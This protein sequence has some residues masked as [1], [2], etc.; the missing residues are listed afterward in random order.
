MRS[1]LSFRI[2]LLQEEDVDWVAGE[3]SAGFL[4]RPGAEP[5]SDRIPRRINGLDRCGRMV[6]RA[7]RRGVCHGTRIV[8]AFDQEMRAEERTS[9]RCFD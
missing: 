6:N 1:V 4:D 8:A 3:L 9:E 2:V 5:L 7:W